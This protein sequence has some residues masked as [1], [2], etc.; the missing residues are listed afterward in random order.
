MP[1]HAATLVSIDVELDS[2][3]LGDQTNNS[4]GQYR[5]W[6]PAAP[7]GTSFTTTVFIGEWVASD[8]LLKYETFDVCSGHG[9]VEDTI[10]WGDVVIKVLEYTNTGPDPTIFL[11][12]SANVDATLITPGAHDIT[13][14]SDHEDRN[15][16]FDDY[17]FKNVRLIYEPAPELTGDFDGDNMVTVFDLNLVL[18]NWNID[19]SPLVGTLTCPQERYQCLS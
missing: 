17:L 16:N 15:F 19:E 8:G 4:A 3:H 1:G 11:P 14:T 18:F 10:L 2:H 9:G 13:F 6:E 7:E 12:R 5:G